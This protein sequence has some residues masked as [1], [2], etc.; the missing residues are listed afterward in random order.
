[1]RLAKNDFGSFCKK[2]RFSVRFP[3]YNINCSFG[4][5]V[6][7]GLHSSVDV[8]AVF[9]LRL[10]GMTLEMMCFRAELVQLIVS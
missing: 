6:R 2:L 4:F 7:F 8:D 3:F 9:Y 5:S 10:Y 1:V